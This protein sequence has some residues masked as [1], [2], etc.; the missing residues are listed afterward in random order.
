MHENIDL[1]YV[2]EFSVTN[3]LREVPLRM[4]SN[5]AERMNFL[6]RQTKLLMFPLVSGRHVRVPRR[7]MTNCRGSWVVGG[8]RGS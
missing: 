6:E 2:F 8:S 7:S 4:Y 1:P 3:M 5:L